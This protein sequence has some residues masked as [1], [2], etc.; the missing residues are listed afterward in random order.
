MRT[1]VT[2]GQWLQQQ[3]QALDL[4]RDEF[5]Q[6]IGCAA[7]TI[8]KIETGSRRPSKYLAARIAQC[9]AISTEQQ[10]AFLQF[11]RGNSSTFPEAGPDMVEQAP[12]RATPQLHNLPPLLTSFVGRTQETNALRALLGRSDVRLITLTGPGGIGK[13]RL[14]LHVVVQLDT[15]PAHGIFFVD[16]APLRAF[17]LVATVIM[18]SLDI[19]AQPGQ[20]LAAALA[21]FLHDKQ[22]LLVL[23]NFEHVAQAAPLL[24]E[25]LEHAPG[26]KIL[27]TSRM[28]LHILGEHEFA[29]P[30][31]VLPASHT[32]PTQALLAVSSAVA[33]FV[34]RA[35]AI[36]ANLSLTDEH[37]GAIADICIQLEGIPLAIELAAARVQLLS[38]IA[39]RARLGSRMTLLSGG[40]RYAPERHQSLRA[41]VAWSY[42]LLDPDAQLLFARLG[43]LVGKYLIDA[44]E[45]IGTIP[46]DRPIDVLNSLTLL[47]DHNL[48]Q[49]GV[50]ANGEPE[51]MM[52]EV[53]REHALERLAEHGE[54]EALRQ[55][56]A[57][58][59]LA[60]A[61]VAT[62]GVPGPQQKVWLDRLEWH[63][64]NL[65][66]ALHWS[67][68]QHQD[69]LAARLCIALWRFWMAHGHTY[70]GRRW[71]DAC[72]TRRA[73]LPA[74]LCA[75]ILYAAAALAAM[76]AE[77][78]RV[79][80]LSEE[81][82]SLARAAADKERIART[83][84]L[85]G[86]IA[87]YQGNHTRAAALTEEAL[88]LR[89]E[90]G[91]KSGIADEL[92]RLGVL[93]QLRGQYEQAEAIYTEAL[94]LFRE[95]KDAWGSAMV[96]NNQGETMR[97]Q[98]KFT[99]A[100]RAL[101]EG[102]SLQRD[103][104][105]KRGI[106]ISL[107]NL[108]HIALY[109]RDY[110]QVKFL[111]EE[112]LT[113]SQ[114]MGS[115]SEIAGTFNILGYAALYQ[116]DL[117]SS[118]SWF[119]QSLDLQQESGYQEGR[120]WSLEGIAGA[121]AEAGQLACAVRLWA[122]AD[123]LRASMGIPMAA[124]DRDEYEQR[125]RA[126]RASLDAATWAALWADGQA[127]TLDQAITYALDEIGHA[128][129]AQLG[130]NIP[131]VVLS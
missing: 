65:R 125:I 29:V 50:G 59:Y 31:L 64:S 76:Q 12:D 60:F 3:R 43:V 45:A 111:C 6:Q 69:E 105:E 103:I 42:D 7:A 98:G 67:F 32:P 101:Q 19:Q 121:A 95:I 127:L 62:T 15:P 21:A 11:A 63:H 37:M 89:R 129:T 93:A 92:N 56:H 40:L 77:Y 118:I 72:L 33:L 94:T 26:L 38:P 100:K 39:I 90:I 99:E 46:D 130:R 18:R 116:K 30:A 75:D 10:T 84:G 4:T 128:R 91:D 80:E 44:A 107:G 23:D 96:L 35:R 14:A 110:E 124:A 47:L 106:S 86:L 70:E 71:L 66:A 108:S 115:K 61:E 109:Q 123:A 55:H 68:D 113:L 51:F 25:L 28:A 119:A 82:L 88:I 2:F 41:V 36:T 102:L 126:A 49:R 9:L 52:L 34:E 16:L 53:L 8:A 54:T 24:A 85:I 117:A 83:L 114:E 104:G 81:S 74:M 122:A 27:A 73:S 131:T 1:N 5:G 79:I 48:L 20:S 78:P 13:T 112:C 58:Y 97:I 22:L 87:T 120:I 17:E 57:Q